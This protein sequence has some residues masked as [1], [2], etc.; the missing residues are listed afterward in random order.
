MSFE[1][2]KKVKLEDILA[3][4]NGKK[5]P[6]ENGKIPVYG[7][8]GI[9]DF[10]E[11]SNSQGEIIIIGRVGAYCGNVYYENRPCWI[12]DNAIGAKPLEGNS[13][14]FL[15]YK[16]RSLDLHNLRVGSSQPLLTQSIIKEIVVGIP[17]FSEQVEIEAILCAIDDKIELNNTINKNLEEMAQAIFKR[18]FV[19]YEFPNENG[20]PYKSSGGEF[21]ESELGLI[22][23]KWRIAPLSEITNVLM[24]QSPK[25]EFYNT[26]GEGL[27]FHQGVSN[28]G[29]RFPT[30]NTYCTQ[31]LRVAKKGSILISVRAPVGRLNIADEDIIIGR[32]LGAISSKEK[33]NSFVYYLLKR[34]F[35]IEDQHGSGT[36]FNSITKKELENIKV[37]VPNR[38]IVREFENIVINIDGQIFNT[39]KQNVS[40]INIRDTLLPKLMSGEIRV[41]LDQA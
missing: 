37:I 33:C 27:P 24:G 12:S 20:E 22:P 19:D 28:Y 9:M 16:L 15:Y 36:I 4:S 34:I 8:N 39:A 32:G 25:S 21:E 30:H 26:L 23:K 40:L 1:G 2:W 13:G 29:S 41:P 11:I 14:K 10:T 17:A 18:W 35:A 6:L 3:F 38:S 5:R 31:A 7:G